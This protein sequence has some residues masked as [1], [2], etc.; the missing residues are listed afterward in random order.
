[1]F[2]VDN[3]Q[4]VRVLPYTSI[5]S[6]LFT[7]SPLAVLPYIS[8]QSDLFTTSL[9]VV[10]PY[11][12]IQS[13]LSTT[14]SLVV[15]PYTSI[16]SDLSTTSPLVPHFAVVSESSC[17]TYL[18]GSPFSTGESQPLPPWPVQ[19]HWKSSC[20]HTHP[21]VARWSSWYDDRWSREYPTAATS[22]TTAVTRGFPSRYSVFCSIIECLIFRNI[23][24]VV[25]VVDV[26]CVVEVVVLPL[27]RYGCPANIR[28]TS[29]KHVPTVWGNSPH[30]YHDNKYPSELRSG[31]CSY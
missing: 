22:I 23:I 25:V 12:S 30:S 24:V 13:D 3:E 6:D 27:F 10:L 15:L 28:R 29:C 26:S 2:H 14:S 18:F 16:Q 19:P 31:E 1:M 5:Q 20:S 4:T 21:T 9:L 7:T 11:T 8:I 17:V